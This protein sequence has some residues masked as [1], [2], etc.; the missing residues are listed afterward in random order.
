[1]KKRIRDVE[2]EGGYEDSN[3]GSC[4]QGCWSEA[5]GE[6]NARQSSEHEPTAVERVCEGGHG[7]RER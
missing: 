5:G 2:K 4:H 7:G 1:M 3:G 6:R